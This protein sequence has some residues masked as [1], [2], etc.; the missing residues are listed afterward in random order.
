MRRLIRGLRPLAACA[1]S[2]V[3]LSACTTGPGQE[4]PDASLDPLPSLTETATTEPEETTEVIGASDLPEAEEALRLCGVTGYGRDKV[5]RM[6]LVPRARDIPRYIP[7]DPDSPEI[8]SDRPAWVVVFKGEVP[9][10]KQ[11]ESWFDPACVVIDGQSGFFG[12]GPV[13]M[14]DGAM[15][16]PPPPERSPDLQLPKLP[17]LSGGS[18]PTTDAQLAEGEESPTICPDSP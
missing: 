3:L 10:W 11:G 9:M 8:Q 5:D 18:C 17:P 7:L 4:V 2:I 6:G 14:R 13:R 16:T 1:F 15:W 12:I